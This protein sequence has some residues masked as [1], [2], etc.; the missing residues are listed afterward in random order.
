M[1]DLETYTPEELEA[2]EEEYDDEDAEE[3]DEAPVALKIGGKAATKEEKEA[4][5]RSEEYARPPQGQSRPSPPGNYFETERGGRQRRSE[6]QLRTAAAR[7]ALA[8]E[9]IDFEEQAKEVRRKAKILEK[10]FADFGFNVRVVEID[11]GPVITQFEVELEA[12][13]RVSKITSLADDLAIALRVPSVRIVAPIPARTRS[14]SRCP[15][16]TASS[17][18]SAK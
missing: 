14:A 12:G 8:N 15:T 18:A 5:L 10:T 6:W 9:D 4:E 11:T 1:S 2:L 3:E 16:S 7:P 17:S 13:L